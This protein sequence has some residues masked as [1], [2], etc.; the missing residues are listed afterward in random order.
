MLSSLKSLRFHHRLS[1][2]LL[3]ASLGAASHLL[4]ARAQVDSALCTDGTC[5]PA[6]S[7][8]T[9]FDR[10]AYR[11]T[12]GKTEAIIVPGIGRIM[13]YGKVGGPNL[14]WN[15]PTSKGIN[16]GWLNYGG[17]KTWL[18]PQT[19]WPIWLGSVWPPDKALDGSPHEIEVLSGGKLRL[20]TPLS[21]AVGM[22]ISRTL[23]FNEAGELVIEQMA[24]KEKGAPVRAGLW[25]ITQSVPGDAIFLPVNPESAYKNGYY[26][27][28]KS[29]F[30]QTVSM[31]SA[32]LLKY[33]PKPTK[34]GD[35]AKIGLDSPVSALASV[36]DGVA[37]VQK[38]AL[39]KG[40]YPDGADGAG[41]PVEFYVSGDPKV[42]YCELELLGPLKTFKV[43]GKSTHA[44]RWSLHDLPSKDVNA[45]AVVD[46]IQNL[47]YSP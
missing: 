9:Y 7:K 29:K 31:A 41:F 24:V 1:C 33:E 12:D 32:G 15:S 43:G 28:T 44:V 34:A 23:Y 42:F 20:T 39:P 26:W 6:I 25:S 19:D 38:S 22:R 16:W 3:L 37:F 45:P 21:P 8:A 35:G 5:L 27:Q 11:L 18:S 17:D 36:K 10:P 30:E 40:K 4:P 14:L 2:F 47:I 46:A 13:R